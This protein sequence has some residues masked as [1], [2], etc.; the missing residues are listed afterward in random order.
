M[1]RRLWEAVPANSVAGFQ[2]EIALNYTSKKFDRGMGFELVH[3]TSH[4]I[5]EKKYG[6][7]TGVAR[8]VMMIGNVLSIS[9]RLYILE[10]INRGAVRIKE[11]VTALVRASANG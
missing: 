5:K 9:F 6:V 2:V 10:W 7:V 11:R 1:T 3:G 8:R 4:R